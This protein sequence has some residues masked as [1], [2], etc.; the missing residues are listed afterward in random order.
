MLNLIGNL[1]FEYLDKFQAYT[2]NFR[3]I[4][5]QSATKFNPIFLEMK[6]VSLYNLN[7]F[8]MTILICLLLP[9]MFN[10]IHS[11]STFLVHETA[12]KMRTGRIN[13]INTWLALS[14]NNIHQRLSITHRILSK[15]TL[16]SWYVR[17]VSSNKVIREFNK[18]I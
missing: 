16:T 8:F 10:F 7:V 2:T 12:S 3:H 11:S 6:L 18:T 9:F 15:N 4:I 1:L 5:L 13:L 17:C 14:I